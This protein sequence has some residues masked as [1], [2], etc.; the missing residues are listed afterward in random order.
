M[1]AGGKWHHF[2]ADVLTSDILSAF[3]GLLC[4]YCATGLA[5]LQLLQ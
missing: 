2:C 4:L 1:D 5:A 3:D